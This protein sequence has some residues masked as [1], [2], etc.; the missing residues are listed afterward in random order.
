RI[1]AGV[2]DAKMSGQLV[3]K[4]TTTSGDWDIMLL[5]P[6]GRPLWWGSARQNAKFTNVVGASRT[7][8]FALPSVRSGTYSIRLVPRTGGAG[9]PLKV[10]VSSTWGGQRTFNV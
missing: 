7:E 10:E 2:E 9:D 8:V 3:V 5:E 1:P 4:L 6:S